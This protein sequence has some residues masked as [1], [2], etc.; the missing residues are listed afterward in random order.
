[1]RK[2]DPITILFS[3][4]AILSLALIEHCSIGGVLARACNI[5]GEA[6]ALLEGLKLAVLL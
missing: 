4:C 6:A 1:M 5:G 2:R 3:S